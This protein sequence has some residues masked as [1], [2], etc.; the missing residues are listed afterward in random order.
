MIATAT[1]EVHEL[2]K[3]GTHSLLFIPVMDQRFAVCDSYDSAKPYGNMLD[4]GSYHSELL[5]AF[6]ELCKQEG[7]E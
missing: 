1:V 4:N 5:E 2:Y 7:I 3:L 6:K